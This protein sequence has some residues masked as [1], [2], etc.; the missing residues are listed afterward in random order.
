MFFAG[1]QPTRKVNSLKPKEIEKI[2]QG[3]KKILPAA[4]GR[5]GT[6]ADRYVDA[7]G[8]EGE[9]LPLL[10]VYQREEQPCFVCQTKIK[11][12]KMGG[13]SAHFCPKC[14]R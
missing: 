1:V 13:R 12:L 3:I 11:R 7:E 14:Q 6:S 5:R 10:K 2:Y 8:K 4:L 9:Y